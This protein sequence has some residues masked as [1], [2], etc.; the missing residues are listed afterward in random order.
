MLKW[1]PFEAI[2]FINIHSGISHVRRGALTPHR[3]YLAPGVTE[4]KDDRGRGAVERICRQWGEKRSFANSCVYGAPKVQ[5]PA[6]NY[7]VLWLLGAQFV[8]YY[9]TVF[10]FIVTCL[11]FS[12]VMSVVGRVIEM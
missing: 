9:M 1:R 3:S 6:I 10:D 7:A 2:N 4:Y 8:H 12:R 5:L 11:L